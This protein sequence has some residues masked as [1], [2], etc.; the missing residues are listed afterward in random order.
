MINER[1]LM[2]TKISTKEQII[3]KA[4]DLFYHKGFARAS[5]RDLAKSVKVTNAAI[6]NHFKNKDQ[7]LYTIIERLGTRYSERMENV[8]SKHEKPLDR[9]REMVFQHACLVV[10]DQKA[11]KIFFDDV[12]QLSP[13]F[14]K[15]IL[16]QQKAIYGLFKKQISDLENNGLLRPVEK[17]VATFCCFAMI[18]WC[19]RWLKQDGEFSIEEIANSIT[20]I[21]LNG[22]LNREEIHKS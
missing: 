13:K 3:N 14:R 21:F 5:I 19:Y 15:N 2:K 17:V 6:Y 8:L 22:I 1:S 9:L 18:N 11:V 12:S 4:I 7:I 20:D 16:D 10:E